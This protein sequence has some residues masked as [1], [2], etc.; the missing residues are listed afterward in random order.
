MNIAEQTPTP[1]PVKV[2]VGACTFRR[3]QDLS[4]LLRSIGQLDVDEAF[5]L[6]VLI[7]DNDKTPSAE[8]TV[9]TAAA[10]MP[11]PVKYVHEPQSGIPFARN[12]VLQ[13]AGNEGFLA[14]VDDDETVDPLWVRKLIAAQRETGA[15]FVQGPVVMTVEKA[16]DEWWLETTF[17]KQNSFLHLAPI[18][19]SWTNNVLIDLDFVHRNGVSFE[20]ALKFEGGEDTLF[21][22]DVVA[23]GGEGRFAA[24]ALVYEVQG[25]ER[26]SWKW[27][28]YRQYRYGITR[29]K[30]AVL[31]R[32]RLKATAY[33]A[34]RGSAMM[35]IGL[36]KLPGTLI[37]GKKAIVDGMSLMARGAGVFSGYFGRN[38]KEYGA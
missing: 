6:S 38:L 1:K 7:V 14:F 28:L 26:L 12:R 5:D 35:V 17:F 19:E 24:D 4:A 11:F 37:R 27:G 20:R 16:Q 8:Q 10:D 9:L 33:C 36:L 29:A 18:K 30:T 23:K 25:T 3:S 32:S 2:V 13:E 31:R 34:I 21:F 22:Q 15:A